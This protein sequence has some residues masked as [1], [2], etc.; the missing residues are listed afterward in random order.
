MD[1]YK[2][3]TC[4]SCHIM[5]Y[6]YV[7]PPLKKQ[8]Q[9]PAPRPPA[10]HSPPPPPTNLHSSVKPGSF[11]D[12]GS[13]SGPGS[14]SLSNTFSTPQRKPSPP[15]ASRP[16]PPPPQLTPDSFPGPTLGPGQS[17]D[18]DNFIPDFDP[19][20]ELE[21][22]MNSIGDDFKDFNFERD[23]PR[24]VRQVRQCCIRLTIS[25]EVTHMSFFSVPFDSRADQWWGGSGRSTLASFPL[26]PPAA[27]GGGP[28]PA[29]GGG[30][31]S[32]RTGSP[33]EQILMAFTQIRSISACQDETMIFLYLQRLSGFQKNRVN[34]VQ[35]FND[36]ITHI[37]QL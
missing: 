10:I 27:R 12:F 28:T 18:F 29:S 37:A 17:S 2:V 5:G 7:Y 22:F 25:L 9:S 24:P 33:G 3:P 1:I 8:D 15:A 23:S 21:A 34:L 11:I 19:Q 26:V 13:S 30:T 16:P 14:G 4:C 35:W 31:G 32:G 6:S 20:E 36:N